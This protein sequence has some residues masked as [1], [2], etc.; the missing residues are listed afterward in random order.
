MATVDQF[1]LAAVA[2]VRAFNSATAVTQLA[3]RALSADQAYSLL[4][5]AEVLTQLMPQTF[6]RLGLAVG[7][8]LTT[9]GDP[10]NID[11]VITAAAAH[12]AEAAQLISDASEKIAPL[13]DHSDVED[14]RRRRRPMVEGIRRWVSKAA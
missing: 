13:L 8:P 14:A 5:A 10:A 2:N 12:M 4:D 11:L 9:R 6:I 7:Q 3:D 1:L